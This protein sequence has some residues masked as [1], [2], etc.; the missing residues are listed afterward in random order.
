MGDATWQRLQGYG[1]IR[2]VHLSANRG[3]HDTHERLQADTFGLAWAI[4]R[5]RDGVPVV[6]ECY[7]HRMGDAERREQVAIAKGDP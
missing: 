1:D 4:E 7:M 6:L 2:E 3:R 5:G